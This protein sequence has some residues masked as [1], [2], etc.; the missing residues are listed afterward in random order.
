MRD[1]YLFLYLLSVLRQRLNISFSMATDSFATS[2]S[3]FFR[4]SL[5]LTLV[6][7]HTTTL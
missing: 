1:R 4:S 3:V 6:E 5:S 7:R 2:V